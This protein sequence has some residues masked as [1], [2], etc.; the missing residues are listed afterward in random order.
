MPFYVRND[1]PTDTRV[2]IYTLD[3]MI[4]HNTDGTLTIM[5]V[6]APCGTIALWNDPGAA[7]VRTWQVAPTLPA[8]SVVVDRD[9][10]MPQPLTLSPAP[11]PS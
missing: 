4:T 6:D 9:T 5:H 11:A 8:E 7:G 10:A 2:Q 1:H 3:E